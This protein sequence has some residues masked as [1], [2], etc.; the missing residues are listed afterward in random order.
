MQKAK[1]TTG[2]RALKPYIEPFYTI[3]LNFIN[4]YT[5]LAIRTFLSSSLL[6]SFA[7]FTPTS[8]KTEY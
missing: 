1:S 5:E 2:G 7:S 4:P 6:I 8:C 3:L